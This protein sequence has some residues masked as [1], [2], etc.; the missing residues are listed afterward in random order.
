MIW[1]GT[2]V[3]YL[4]KRTPVGVLVLVLPG[5]HHHTMDIQSGYTPG[6]ECFYGLALDLIIYYYHTYIP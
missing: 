2:S 3:V 5:Q 4:E 6:E 1:I